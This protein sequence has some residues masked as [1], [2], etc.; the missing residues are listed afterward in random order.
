MGAQW[1]G[2]GTLPWGARAA[3]PTCRP[4]RC[5]STASLGES[6][7]SGGWSAPPMPPMPPPPPRGAAVRACWPRRPWDGLHLF[8]L[9]FY[10]GRG[11]KC[12]I[13]SNFSSERGGAC[14]PL[15]GLRHDETTTY[16]LTGA[17][18]GGGP[19]EERRRARCLRPRGNLM[20]TKPV[21][22]FFKIA[23]TPLPSHHTPRPQ[24]TRMKK[25]KA[26]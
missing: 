26:A 3:R 10:R 17:G 25:A 5:A 14:V 23:T 19:G 9:F 20:C 4:R 15:A 21:P 1:V 8:F 22:C 24:E 12:A 2:Q 16:A 6:G 11:E 13:I 18:Q 7:R